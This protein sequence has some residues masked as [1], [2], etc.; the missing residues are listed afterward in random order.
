M[1]NA[2]TIQHLETLWKVNNMDGNSRA[3]VFELSQYSGE[4]DLELILCTENVGSFEKSLKFRN[5]GKL[6]GVFSFEYDGVQFLQ[7]KNKET[8]L[9]PKSILEK[10]IEKTLKVF[11]EFAKRK[12]FAHCLTLGFYPTSKTHVFYHIWMGN[13]KGK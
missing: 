7:D 3:I 11:E 10:D 13:D 1:K 4:D 12:S 2:L 8:I 9:F 6:N 5:S